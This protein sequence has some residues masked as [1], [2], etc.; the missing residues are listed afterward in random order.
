M[1]SPTNAKVA[2]VFHLG[3]VRTA[4]VRLYTKANKIVPS[5]QE[6]SGAAHQMD[7]SVPNLDAWKCALRLEVE[8]WCCS[9]EDLKELAAKRM[10]RVERVS[11]CHFVVSFAIVYFCASDQF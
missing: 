11:S 6:V 9:Q 4:P 7:V 5:C 3:R 10:V 2:S 1:E 8:Q